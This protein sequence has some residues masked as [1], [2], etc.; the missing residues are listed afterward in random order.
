MHVSEI[1]TGLVHTVRAEDTLEKASR[2]MRDA[3]VGFLPVV[4][5]AGVVEVHAGQDVIDSIGFRPVVEESIIVGV[6]TDRDIV[7]RAVST[8]K[9]PKTTRVTE[10]MTKQFACC[11][12]DCD[13][14]EAVAVMDQR[15]VHRVFVLNHREQ[16]VGVVSLENISAAEAR[17]S[18]E[19]PEAL[20]A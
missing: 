13:S 14:A 20:T 11:H 4:E 18:D 6:L 12:V 16:V 10:V 3:K 1:M 7:L 2:L 5:E 17:Q 9:D 19:V 15:K 8:G